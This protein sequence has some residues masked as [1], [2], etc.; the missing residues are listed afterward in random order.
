MS[1]RYSTSPALH[2]RIGKSRLRATLYSALCLACIYAF[3]LLYERGYVGFVVLLALLVTGLLWRLRRDPMVGVELRWHQGLWTLEQNGVHRTI[4]PTRRS[5]AMP[6]VIY[7]AFSDLPAGP[8]GYMWLYA[9]CST[10]QQLRRLRVRLTL[11]Y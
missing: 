4:C 11:E 6:W 1:T 5:T 9:D 10:R 2:L 7:L 3:W 8:G